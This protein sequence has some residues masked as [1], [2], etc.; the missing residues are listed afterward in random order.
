MQQCKSD[1]AVDKEVII[2]QSSTPEVPAIDGSLPGY[3][4]VT[5]NQYIIKVGNSVKV[6]VKLVD[7]QGGAVAQPVFSWVSSQP[8]IAK[9]AADGTITGMS[10]GSTML[11]VTDGKHGTNQ[12]L[13]TVV[14]PSEVVSVKPVNASFDRPILLVPV[15]GTQKLDYSL[16]NAS[17]QIVSGNA[18]FFA[19]AA[20]RDL[21]VANGTVSVNKAGVFTVAARVTSDTLSGAVTIIAYNPPATSGSCDTS[22]KVTSVAMQNCPRKMLPG[23][24]SAPLKVNVIRMRSCYTSLNNI[25]RIT[26]ETPTQLKVGLATVASGISNGQIRAMKPGFT[27]ISAQVGSVS[28]DPLYLDVLVDIGGKWAFSG[29]DGKVGVVEFPKKNPAVEYYN[30][31]DAASGARNEA[32]NYN[33][34]GSSCLRE[35][36]GQAFCQGGAG[37]QLLRSYPGKLY[38]QAGSGPE[39]RGPG[40][41]LG[42][43]EA[44]GSLELCAGSGTLLF[45]DE[46]V[47]ATSAYTLTKNSDASCTVNETIT[48]DQGCYN[49]ACQK[50]AWLTGGSSKRWINYDSFTDVDGSINTLEEILTFKTDGSVQFDRVKVYRKTGA[51][52]A[53]PTE[54]YKWCLPSCRDKMFF[55]AFDTQKKCVTEE[56]NIVVSQNS[57]TF[58]INGDEGSTYTPF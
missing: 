35:A 49:A 47:L 6:P 23:S 15:G 31:Q 54:N 2:F 4:Y 50:S 38:G 39:W 53:F 20:N 41:L 48:C 44:V 46:N 37:A 57:L 58:K 19:N 42:T 14:K 26:Q 9:V 55:A 12:V 3:I 21:S 18:D 32:R 13:V 10:E 33:L 1:S 8:T 22:F 25:V 29:K 51:R 5:Q 40:A 34:S 24:V 27:S 56:V 43:G 45:Q 28:S 17:G 36:S 7:S 16:T 11:E 52:E 30:P